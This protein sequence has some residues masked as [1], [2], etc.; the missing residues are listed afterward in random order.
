MGWLTKFLKGS[1]HNHKISEGQYHGKYEEEGIWDG[2]SPAAAWSDSE[3]ED[4]D[5]AIAI[6]LSEEDQKG[7]KV[8]DNDSH[9]EEDEQLAK[10]L[11]ESM[12]MDSPPRYDYG[13]LFPPYP[14]FNPSGYRICAGCNAEIGHGRFLSCMGGVWHPECFCCNACNMPISD[15]E[16]QI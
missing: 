4:I 5:R 13:S 14:Y 8:I 15:Y 10:A 2:P 9:L 11:Q 7:K 3:N 6:S 1:S 16:V 12:K